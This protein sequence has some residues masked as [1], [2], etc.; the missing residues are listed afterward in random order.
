MLH[1]PNCG[2]FAELKYY[3]R[4]KRAAINSSG[5]RE[6]YSLR[7]LRCMK[8]KRMHTEIPDCL[9]PYKR[10]ES[11]VFEAIH[12]TCITN[13]GRVSIKNLYLPYVP[14]DLNTIRR[15]LKWLKRMLEHYKGVY[16]HLTSVYFD[17]KS[18]ELNF[19]NYARLI[20]NSGFW[21]STRS[22]LLI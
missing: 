1:C 19:K 3:D 12:E 2:V 8:C 17:Y 15:M 10:Y 7:R 9:I 5:K 4:R 18:L 14:S 6:I 11:A 21:I 13:N 16:Q 22:V 20:V